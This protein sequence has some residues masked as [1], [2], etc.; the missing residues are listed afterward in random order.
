MITWKE[1]VNRYAKFLKEKN[2]AMSIV[3]RTRRNVPGTTVGGAAHDLGF[4]Q[5]GA[6]NDCL[7]LNFRQN[8]P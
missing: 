5:G 2:T 4:D 1:N 7:N 3:L 8:F 6:G